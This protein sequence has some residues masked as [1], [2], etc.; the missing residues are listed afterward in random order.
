VSDRCVGAV[1]CGAFLTRT[2]VERFD[3]ASIGAKED[4]LFI[5]LRKRIC[6]SNKYHN[7]DM[8]GAQTI[9]E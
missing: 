2:D 6:G 7:K 4:V 9:I 3:F 8:S 5:G 1:G